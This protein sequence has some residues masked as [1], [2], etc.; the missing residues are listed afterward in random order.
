MTITV[1]MMLAGCGQP[2]PAANVT[3][4]TANTTVEAAPAPQNATVAPV[5]NTSVAHT[6]HLASNTGGF[7]AAIKVKNADA[8]PT[9]TALNMSVR[10]VDIQ[11]DNTSQWVN[12]FSQRSYPNLKDLDGNAFQVGLNMVPA[13]KYKAVRIQLGTSGDAYTDRTVSYNVPY[14]YLQAVQ[15]FEVKG[16]QTLVMVF[17]IDLGKSATDTNGSIIL[18]PQGTITLLADPQVTNLGDNRVS[19][20]GGDQ[21]F[22]LT[23]SY[24]EMLP[25]GTIETVKKDCNESCPGNCITKSTACT[26]ACKTSVVVGCQLGGD[27]CR[28]DCDPYL[29]P[30]DC[31]DKCTQDSESNCEYDLIGLCQQACDAKYAA[32]CVAACQAACYS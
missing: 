15:P 30:W 29:Q 14:D 19:I 13:K 9:I 27:K 23:Q 11:S 28:E 26:T 20:T 7:I 17:E 6:V 5:E 31:R 18:K 32:P 8:A 21:V 3:A 12:I 25:P 10:A 16:D 4:T 1:L 22:S 24:D 2:A